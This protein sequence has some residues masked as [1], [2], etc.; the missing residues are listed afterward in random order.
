MTGLMDLLSSLFCSKCRAKLLNLE[1]ENHELTEEKT[2][3]IR[4]YQNLMMEKLRLVLDCGKDTLELHNRIQELE[5]IIDQLEEDN[6]ESFNWPK[7]PNYSYA[8]YDVSGVRDFYDIEF[9]RADVQY[10]L[11]SKE[12]WVTMLTAI[13]PLVKEA[14]TRWTVDISDCDN[15]SSVMSA[16]VSIAFKKSGYSKQGAFA[17]AH[18]SSD[19]Y[20]RHAYNLFVDLDHKVWLYEPQNNTLKG[21]IQDG[22]GIFNTGYVWFLN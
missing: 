20:S 2:I 8:S 18:T 16:F 11:F 17:I 6:L 5:A 13:H 4:N 1:S 22:E 3:L 12:D 10:H 21:L 7:I 14:L 19:E 9:V 15:Y